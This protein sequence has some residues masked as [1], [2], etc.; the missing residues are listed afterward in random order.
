MRIPVTMPNR[1]F[2]A[3]PRVRPDDTL[4]AVAETPRFLVG[5]DFSPGS[6]RA[7][8]EAR[9]LASMCG[10]AITV[11][12]VRPASDIRAAIREER[13]DLVGTGG[14]VLTRE[15]AEHY[16]RRLAKWTRASGGR[17]RPRPA[18]RPRRGAGQRGA[19]RLHAPRPRKHGPERRGDAPDG[20]DRRASPGPRDDSGPGRSELERA[21]RAGPVSGF[22]LRA[23]ERGSAP[24]G[25]RTGAASPASSTAPDGSPSHGRGRSRRP[26]PVGPRSRRRG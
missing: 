9:R 18:R 24:R 14:R 5:I 15:L 10:A 22:R 6:R 1:N 8:D 7:L 2:M 23:R 16:A 25:R 21:G 20:R 13:G 3:P 4:R 12:H 17:A 11:A 26:S 19:A